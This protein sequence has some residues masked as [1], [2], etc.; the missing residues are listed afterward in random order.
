MN[1]SEA[2]TFVCCVEPGL[3]EPM[4]LRLLESLRRHG[5]RFA[6]ARFIA[7]QPRLAPPISKATR[8]EIERLGGE[9]LWLWQPRKMDWYH[10][11]NKP[12]SLL[13]L[14]QKISTPWVTFLDSDML[15]ARE[16]SE[17]VSPTVD[18]LACAPDD[19]LV[20]S[21]GPSHPMDATWLQ[22]I[23]AIGLDPS[24]IPMIREYNTGKS[25]RLYFNSGA[26]SYRRSTGFAKTYWDVMHHVLSLN[27]G[28]PNYGEHFTDQVVLGLCA[29]KAGL[30]W[31]GLSIGYN[32]AVDRSVEEL[33]DATFKAA[34]LLHYHKALE[35][36]PSRF[37]NRLETNHSELAGWLVPK[38]RLEDPRSQVSGAVCEVLRVARG[39]PRALYRKRVRDAQR[40]GQTAQ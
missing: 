26:F 40:Q 8:D 19:G 21:T 23:R 2:T 29:L 30:R 12:A 27:L 1:Q 17:L 9:H 33:P 24:E 10:Y 16:P 20:G 3:L 38:G 39:V 36:D 31:Q 34:T 28:F 11:L 7:C 37:F 18:F 25:I 13:H 15:I 14:D 4:A 35:H 22:Y 6:D 32:L 5:G